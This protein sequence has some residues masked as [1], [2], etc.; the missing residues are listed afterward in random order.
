MKHSLY[1]PLFLLLVL[2]QNASALFWNLDAYKAG[3]QSNGGGTNCATCSVLVSLIEQLAVIHDK[4]VEQV[5]DEICD[6]FPEEVAGLCTYLVDTYG[7]QVIKYLTM[8]NTADEVCLNMGVCTDPTCRMYP[9]SPHFPR[10]TPKKASQPEATSTECSTYPQEAQKLCEMIVRLA[11]QHE[12]FE[13]HDHDL[14]SS[15]NELRGADWRGRDCDDLDGTMYPGR[16]NTDKSALIDHNCNGIHGVDPITRRTYEDEFC[17][18]TQPRGV[19][20]VGDSAGAHFSIPPSWLN[21]SEITKGTYSDLISILEDELDWPMRSA[22]TG[23]VTSPDNTTV[24]IDSIYLRLV[25]HNRCN[26]RDYQNVGVN[27]CRSGSMQDNVIHSLARNQTQDHPLLI[28]FELIGN[29]VCSGH[30]NYWDTMTTPE[31]F[32]DNIV[33]SLEY[34]DTVLP[35]GSHVVFLGLAN[36]LVLWD[37]MWNRTHPIGITYQTFYDYLNCLEISPCYVW[38]NSNETIRE[39]GQARADELSAVYNDILAEYTFKNFDMAYYDFPFDP[40]NDVWLARGGQTWQLIEPTD[41]FHPSQIANA[42]I[43]EW[44]WNTIS[45]DHPDFLGPENPN[46]DAIQTIFGAQG[47]Y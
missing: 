21:A 7:D 14:H 47:G 34:L 38:M 46:N 19:A 44:F 11:D 13:D 24:P 23:W 29:D 4:E 30:P 17:S 26:H 27:G 28:L 31:E 25:E 35:A 12:P 18:G 32:H 15:I 10:N 20:V 9:P 8:K 42:L 6:L 33:L 22:T 45:V 37:N 16:K 3:Y 43:A 5:V 41:G 1:V 39:E 40:I 36:G 2:S